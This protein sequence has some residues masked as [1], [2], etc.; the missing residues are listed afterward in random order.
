MES[1]SGENQF[2]RI[3]FWTVTQPSGDIR[4]SLSPEAARFLH[5]TGA[6]PKVLPHRKSIKAA[7]LARISASALTRGEPLYC[8]CGFLKLKEKQSFSGFHGL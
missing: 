5:G 7:N 1:I 6:S 3:D 8:T 4:L 2:V